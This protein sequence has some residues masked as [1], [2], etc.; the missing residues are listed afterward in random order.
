MNKGYLA[1]VAGLV[2]LAVAGCGG[3]GANSS[4]QAG[5]S[6]ASDVASGAIV[7]VAAGEFYFHPDKTTVPAGK[8]TFVVTNEGQVGHEMVVV[9]TDAKAAELPFAD[10]EAS[11]EGAVDEIPEDGLEVGA[12]GRLTL[13]LQPGHY[14]LLCN[15]PGHYKGGMY[16]DLTVS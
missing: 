11:E 1:A 12:T 13:D 5:S 9:K 16:A 6:A 4:S 3:S 10:G 2:A 14:V 15:L 7:N 8:V